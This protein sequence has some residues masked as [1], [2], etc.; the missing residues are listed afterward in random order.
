MCSLSF[1]RNCVDVVWTGIYCHSLKV[2]LVLCIR[3][4]T[5]TAVGHSGL[6]LC[7]NLCIS[8]DGHQCNFLSLIVMNCVILGLPVH[9]LGEEMDMHPLNIGQGIMWI[10]YIQR[11]SVFSLQSDSCRKKPSLQF[12]AVKR[13]PRYPVFAA[14]HLFKSF[15]SGCGAVSSLRLSLSFLWLTVSIT[16]HICCFGSSKIFLWEVSA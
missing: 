3:V 15:W 10:P 9:V 8:S 11:M 1:T 12:W 16:F 7:H 5:V 4:F 13:G 2:V 14:S 6:W